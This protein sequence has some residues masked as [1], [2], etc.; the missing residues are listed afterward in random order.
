MFADKADGFD[1]IGAIRD[2]MLKEEV[3]P[4]IHRE[5]VQIGKGKW[6][7]GK[8]LA[9]SLYCFHKAGQIMGQF[10][11]RQSCGNK[12]FY[13]FLNSL[14]RMEAENSVRITNRLKRGLIFRSLN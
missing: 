4:I 8:R 7:H 6:R 1:E 13:Q 14:L 9:E 11:L 12:G 2:C 10:K 3:V 5:I